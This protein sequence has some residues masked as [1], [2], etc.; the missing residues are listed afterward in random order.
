L[1]TQSKFRW[2]RAPIP[3]DEFPVGPGGGL[4]LGRPWKWF[5]AGGRSA[6][7]RTLFARDPAKEEYRIWQCQSDN[8]TSALTLRIE[9]HGAAP[10]WHVHSADGASPLLAERHAIPAAGFPATA[11]DGRQP[12]FPAERM[13][14]DTVAHLSERLAH[15]A[16]DITLRPVPFGLAIGL[17]ERRLMGDCPAIYVS[18]LGR[19]TPVF[20]LEDDG[21]TIPALQASG[22]LPAADYMLLHDILG[23]RTKG[24][25][26]FSP[27][28][29]TLFTPYFTAD[30]LAGRMG[31]FAQVLGT[32]AAILNAHQ[33]GHPREHH[34]RSDEGGEATVSEVPDAPQRCGGSPLAN[35][36]AWT[37]AASYVTV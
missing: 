29:R 33:T 21:V 2:Q 37:R 32:F 23:S 19:N 18:Q 13:S 3:W 11:A 16:E 22:A 20:R 26:H 5:V 9:H 1:T 31:E 35:G 28:M 17:T 27:D 14:G 12:P 4:R 30:E 34:P 15:P 8:G 7:R 24:R 36:N 6:P 10:G 25:L